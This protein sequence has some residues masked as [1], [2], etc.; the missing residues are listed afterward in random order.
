MGKAV[1]DEAVLRW[2]NV[3]GRRAPVDL[4]PGFPG[5]KPDSPGAQTAMAVGYGGWKKASVM[6]L[7]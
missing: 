1:N 4:S 6:D 5:W 3:S 2:L 7:T